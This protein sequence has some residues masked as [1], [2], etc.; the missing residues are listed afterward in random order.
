MLY[1]RGKI[2]RNLE[3]RVSPFGSMGMGQRWRDLEKRC[4]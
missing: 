4:H 1:R 2:F 3:L